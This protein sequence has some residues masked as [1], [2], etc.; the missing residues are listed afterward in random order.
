MTR[1]FMSIYGSI[2]N[3]LLYLHCAFVANPYS[4]E[5]EVLRAP[6]W[7]STEIFDNCN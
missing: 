6:N 4:D 5:S 3:A 7:R 2:I 1:Y